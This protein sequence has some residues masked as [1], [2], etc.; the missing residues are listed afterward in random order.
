MHTRSEK[1]ISWVSTLVVSA[2]WKGLDH[3]ARAED[4]FLS[5]KRALGGV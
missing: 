5:L 2:Q 1:D 3:P 4:G